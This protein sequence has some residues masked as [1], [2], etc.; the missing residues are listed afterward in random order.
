MEEEHAVTLTVVL[1][2]KELEALQ[3]M[4]KNHEAELHKAGLTTATW[5]PEDVASS[6]L[7][8]AL[9]AEKH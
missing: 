8:K 4:A 9:R 2:N 5:T 3:T 6:L 1:S 7:R